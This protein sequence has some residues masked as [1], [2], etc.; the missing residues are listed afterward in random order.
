MD[1]LFKRILLAYKKVYPNYSDDILLIKKLYVH[2][3]TVGNFNNNI[4]GVN[5][6]KIAK[7]IEVVENKKKFT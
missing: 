2:F 1:F 4:L 5:A 7:E 3:L 6:R